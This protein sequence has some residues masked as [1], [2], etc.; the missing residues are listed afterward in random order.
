MIRHR[1]VRPSWPAASDYARERRTPRMRSRPS[2]TPSSAMGFTPPFPQRHAGRRGFNDDVVSPPTSSP[3]YRPCP[4]PRPRPLPP[5]SLVRTGAPVRWR[6]AVARSRARRHRRSILIV[7]LKI[8]SKYRWSNFNAKKN[9][10]AK[11]QFL[12]VLKEM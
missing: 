4:C 10:Q 2:N 1:R 7:L 3:R 5:P 9:L 6:A 11:F 12:Q 8:V